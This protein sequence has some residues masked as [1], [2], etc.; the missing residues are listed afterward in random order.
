MFSRPATPDVIEERP[1]V[2]PWGSKFNSRNPSPAPVDPEDDDNDVFHDA[3]DF[4]DTDP[5]FFAN[6][7]IVVPDATPTEYKMTKIDKA[8]ASIPI[9]HTNLASL[10]NCRASCDH[11]HQ[12]FVSSTD[13]AAHCGHDHSSFASR[14]QCRLTCEHT[15][16]D[17]QQVGVNSALSQLIAVEGWS[18]RG[19]NPTTNHPGRAL[20]VWAGGF[21]YYYARGQSVSFAI[22]NDLPPGYYF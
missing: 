6:V 16:S 20:Q 10:T 9:S 14:S 5:I 3:L 2:T 18:A 1:F 19:V 12:D 21:R 4:D 7:S 15:S 22:P 13:C 8:N 17:F 11:S